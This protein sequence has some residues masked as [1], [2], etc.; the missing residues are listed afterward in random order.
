MSQQGIS[1]HWVVTEKLKGGE[2]VTKARLVARGFEEDS[3]GS[4]KDTLTCAK[5]TVRI[6][7]PNASTKTWMCHLLDVKASYLQG[8]SIERDVFLRLPEEFYCGKLSKLNKTVYGLCDA[9]RAWCLRVKDEIIKL[10]VKLSS[11]DS[12]LFSCKSEHDL[13]IYFGVTLQNSRR[14]S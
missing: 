10:G 11:Y 3:S 7:L 6:V 14:Y 8:N 4:R 5:E 12:A 2:M 9:A 1:V 13:E